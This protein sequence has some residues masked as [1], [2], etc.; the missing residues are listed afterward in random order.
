MEKKTPMKIFIIMASFDAIASILAV[1]GGNHTS[2]PLQL[3]LGKGDIILVMIGGL[4]LT[5]LG[6]MK[7]KYTCFHYLGVIFILTGVIII[8][9]PKLLGKSDENNTLLGI[10]IFTSS[11]LP[12]ALSILYK[13][14]VFKKRKLGPIFCNARIAYWQLLFSI[15][16]I[17]IICIP[18][19]GSIPI[20]ELPNNLLAGLKC[21]FLQEDSQQHDEC[22]NG[23]LILIVYTIINI[24][25]N[26]LIVATIRWGS[27]AL[28]II[29]ATVALPIASILF[30]QKWIMGVHAIPFDWVYWISFIFVLLGIISYKYKPDQFIEEDEEINSGSSWDE[31]IHDQLYNEDG[32]SDNNSNLKNESTHESSLR[33]DQFSTHERKSNSELFPGWG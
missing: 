22:N 6:M 28:C 17:P 15:L 29:S 21:I 2:G 5:K 9:T 20:K 3:L 13:E 27:A 19:L 23:W 8:I 1:I 24:V 18:G 12:T 32:F 7:T 26:L 31:D 16:L 4:I 33:N 25:Y 11:V 10:T 30:S 14:I